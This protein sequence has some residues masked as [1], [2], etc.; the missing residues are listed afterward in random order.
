MPHIPEL[1]TAPPPEGWLG[2]DFFAAGVF[3]ADGEAAGA[4]ALGI[5]RSPLRDA[6]SAVSRSRTWLGLA[7]WP[8]LAANG[9]GSPAGPML[10]APAAAP[11]STPASARAEINGTNVRDRR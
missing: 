10:I 7:G 4:D 2:V 9:C 8:P 6:R 11:T 1:A 3:A 5:A